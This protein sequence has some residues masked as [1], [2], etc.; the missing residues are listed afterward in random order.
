[1][2]KNE[3][4]DCVHN[5]FLVKQNIS[6]E[7]GKNYGLSVID[8]NILTFVDICGKNTTATDIEQRRKIKKNTISVHVDAL[9]RK[10]LLER[11]EVSDDRRKAELRLTAKGKEIAQQC[12]ERRCE[13][14]RKLQEGLTEQE[15]ATLNHCFEIVNKNA[16]SLLSNWQIEKDK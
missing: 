6:E 2:H 8:V 5:V 7:I 13:F 14:G 12:I 15:I 1:M 11:S 3:L 16:L 4:L 10:K 9:V